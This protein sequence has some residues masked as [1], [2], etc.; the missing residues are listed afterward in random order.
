MPLRRALFLC[1]L[2]LLVGLEMGLI[3]GVTL[4]R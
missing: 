1:I 2:Y 4:W 3:V